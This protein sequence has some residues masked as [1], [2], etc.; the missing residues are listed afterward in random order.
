MFYDTEGKNIVPLEESR[1]YKEDFIGLRKLNE[2]GKLIF[3][4]FKDEHII[5]NIVEYWEEIVDFFLD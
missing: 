5:Y 2:E 3:T 1:F 4:E